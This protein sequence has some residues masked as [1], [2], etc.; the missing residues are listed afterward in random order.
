MRASPESEARTSQQVRRLNLHRMLTAAMEKTEPFTRA[1]IVQVTGLSVPTVGTLSEAL[2]KAGLLRDAGVGPSRGGRRPS[3]LEFDSRCAFVVGVALGA[4]HTHVAVSDLRGDRL[5]HRM[6]ATPLVGPRRLLG[7]IAGA[8]RDVVRE[9]GVPREKV[10]AAAIGVPGAVDREQ[11]TVVALTPNLKGWVN[12]AVAKE[13]GRSL[14]TTWIVENDVNLAVLGERWRG[15]AQ[16]HDTCAFIHAGTGIGA[17]IVVDGHLHRGHQFQAGE[18]GLMCMGKQYLPMDFGSRGCLESLAGAATLQSRW[19][20]SKDHGRHG[21]TEIL[22][23]AEVGQARARRLVGEAAVL[24]GIAAA[25]LALVLDPSLI[26]VGGALAHGSPFLDEVK[27]V[28]G[29]IIPK[30]PG[31]VASQ[32]GRE[33]ALW[34]ALAVAV[35]EARAHLRDRLGARPPTS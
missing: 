10:L 1:E 11:G 22:A 33:A 21:L 3:F 5:G 8:V 28:V 31:V 12:V 34:G 16:G 17:G 27:R 24:I 2:L 32:L 15:A 18:I 30:P 9:A 26:V 14:P 13:L 7:R 23:A 19:S 20:T 25:H 6:M 4:T 29:H 35:T